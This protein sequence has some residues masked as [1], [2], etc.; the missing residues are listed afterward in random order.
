M[1]EAPPATGSWMQRRTFLCVP[2]P[3]SVSTICSFLQNPEVFHTAEATASAR[4]LQEALTAVDPSY[5]YPA[6]VWYIPDDVQKNE[7]EMYIF[8]SL[9][10]L[11]YK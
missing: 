7:I 1:P 5:K 2:A 3:G 8:P 6:S 4:L 9:K 11:V 10:T